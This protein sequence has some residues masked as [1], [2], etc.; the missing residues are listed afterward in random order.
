VEGA[1]PA[2]TRGLC[3]LIEKVAGI[4]QKQGFLSIRDFSSIQY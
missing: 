1:S 3:S 2:I 4:V